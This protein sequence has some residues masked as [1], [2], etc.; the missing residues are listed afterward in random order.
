MLSEKGNLLL[1]HLLV[2]FIEESQMS[3]GIV[4]GGW[5]EEKNTCSFFSVHTGVR[6]TNAL[7]ALSI[8]EEMES[9]ES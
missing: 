1:N 4:V 8:Y 6:C 5:K 2:S 3:H 7:I 9:G